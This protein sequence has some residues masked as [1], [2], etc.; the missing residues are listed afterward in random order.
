MTERTVRRVVNCSIENPFFSAK[1]ILQDL[2]LTDKFCIT[3]IKNIF[4]KNDQKSYIAE[5]VPFL[6]DVQKENRLRFV[7]EHIR[8]EPTFWIPIDFSDECRFELC[9]RGKVRVR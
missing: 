4:K 8:K 1:Q 3:T 6:T 2:K 9:H 5:E 7:Q